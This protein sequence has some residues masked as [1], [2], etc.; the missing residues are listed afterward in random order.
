[1]SFNNHFLHYL[2]EKA[3][4]GIDEEGRDICGKLR[5]KN[6]IPPRT[7][8]NVRYSH[9]N[10]SRT[11]KL[12]SESPGE[13]KAE[14]RLGWTLRSSNGFARPQSSFVSF[15]FVPFPIPAFLTALTS[16]I[17]SLCL[18]PFPLPHQ[19]AHKLL[20]SDV[21]RLSTSANRRE[22]SLPK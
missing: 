16:H 1:M 4:H 14:K 17:S 20:K 5:K 8:G 15:L 11:T 9:K 7:E 6:L 13:R 2:S 10:V 12:G 21:K 3:E 22:R 18:R 19:S